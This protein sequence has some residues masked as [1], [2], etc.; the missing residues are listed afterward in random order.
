MSPRRSMLQSKILLSLNSTPVETITE[1]STVV[2]AS[3]P[4]VSRSIKNLQ[5]QSLVKKTERGWFITELGI[6]QL[7]QSREQLSKITEMTAQMIN[8]SRE[9]LHFIV[10]EHL[11][12]VMSTYRNIGNEVSKTTNKLVEGISISIN[13]QMQDLFSD[14][15]KKVTRSV[16]LAKSNA[17][18]FG[19]YLHRTNFWIPPSASFGLFSKLGMLTNDPSLTDE[20]FS[21]AFV[22]FYADNEWREL[23][24]L[25]S[26]WKHN[27]FFKKRMPIFFE[28]LEAHIS[29]LY[30][31]S[32]STLLPQIE[33][34]LFSLLHLPPGQRIRE[35]LYSIISNEFKEYLHAS[36]KDSMLGYVNSMAFVF[37]EFDKFDE[38]L[39]QS[40]FDEEQVM[41]RNTILHGVQ[42]NFG[43]VENSLRAFLML[44][45]LSSVKRLEWD[46]RY[47][48]IMNR[49]SN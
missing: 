13:S 41:N 35:N 45:V 12:E 34:V 39:E 4:S 32:I 44:D 18:K 1:L 33:G 5:E 2:M 27:P 43:T 7:N 6:N 26:E 3:R 38:W 23:Q 22:D 31:A 15:G 25:V 16:E 24:N 9:A 28:A 46:E 36:S 21:Q 40:G 29:G 20:E 17:E 14:L 30:S 11:D 19:S 48:I 10:G 49:H 8:K 37:I 42:I 47:R